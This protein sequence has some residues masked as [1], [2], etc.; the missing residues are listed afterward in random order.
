MFHLVSPSVPLTIE[1]NDRMNH[2]LEGFMS[3][4]VVAEILSQHLSKK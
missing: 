2:E 4:A 3:E 1:T